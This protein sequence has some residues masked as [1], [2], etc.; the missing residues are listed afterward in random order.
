MYFLSKGGN[1]LSLQRSLERQRIGKVTGG[2]VARA[3][4]FPFGRVSFA[5]SLGIR[6]ARV[7][8]TACGWIRWTGDFAFQD[9]RFHH[10]IR[11]QSR[12]GGHKRFGVRVQWLIEQGC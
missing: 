10:L 7:K 12:D 1:K 8:V 4:F 3:V 11:I 6:A 9:Y 2:E 5:H